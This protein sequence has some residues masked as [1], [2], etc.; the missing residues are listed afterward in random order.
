MSFT[1]GADPEF[2][3]MHHNTLKSAIN[4]LPKKENA[5][6]R[7]GHRYYFDNVLAEIAIVPANNKNEA[8]EN[9]R[10]AL[11]QLAKLVYPGKF[12]IKASGRY[13]EK[14]LNC[15]DA[16]IAGCNPEWDVY[17]LSQVYPP[18]EDIELLDG[19]YKFKTNFR[20]AGGHIHI[21]SKLLEDSI[22]RFAMVRMMDLFLGIP[23]IFLD[24]DP[25]SKDRRKIYGH[26][27]SHRDP[28][29]GLEYRTLGNFWLSSPELTGLIYDLTEFTLQFVQDKKHEEIW[30]TDED[31]LDE[32]DPSIAYT[33]IGYDVDLLIRSINTCNKTKA[34]EFLLF[35]KNYLPD[36]LISGINQLCEKPLE[37]PYTAWKIQ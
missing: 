10:T 18:D 2:M 6:S 1:F 25:T 15:A 29:Y 34:E 32:E 5:V 26:A 36:K 17:S 37:D 12:V 9:V 20:S 4:I 35:A 24:T 31:L 13:P 22:N 19:Y 16:L 33:C 3:I 28:D 14:E 8:L 11:E 21:G 30:T 7:N 23:S 27:G